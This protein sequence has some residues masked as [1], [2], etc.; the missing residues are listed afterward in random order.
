MA[1]SYGQSTSFQIWSDLVFIT[2]LKN[3]SRLE[4]IV[5]YRTNV[6]TT[7]KWW[8]YQAQSTYTKGL[9]NR[10]VAL[11]SLLLNYTNQT[12]SYNTMEIRPVIGLQYFAVRNPKIR[13]SGLFRYE[14][15]AFYN[16]D[17]ATW[18]NDDRLR[19]RVDGGFL[20]IGERFNQ[21][22]S[23]AA[24][25]DV[26]VFYTIDREVMERYASRIRFRAGL[27]Y[28]VTS[29]FRVQAIYAYQASRNSINKAL[30]STMQHILWLRAL[31][32]TK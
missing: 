6:N 9:G 7:E 2:P 21:K 8:T 27:D 23:M 32:T 1:E 20:L 26:E 31:F 12:N 25:S 18:S 28:A 17:S 10:F 14:Y 24:I 22:G 13:V 11:G 4:N 19:F 3:D 16:F 30:N 15:R 5:T 29:H